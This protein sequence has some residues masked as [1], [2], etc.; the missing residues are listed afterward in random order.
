MS[1][2]YEPDPEVIADLQLR[3]ATERDRSRSRPESYEWSPPK[4]VGKWKCRNPECAGFADV[5]EIAMERFFAFSAQLRSR[6]EGSLDPTKILYCEPCQAAYKA[7]APDRRRA[8]VERMAVEIR[9]L[10]ESGDPTR[11]RDLIAQ[12]EE[13]GHPDVDGLVKAITDRRV[14]DSGRAGKRKPL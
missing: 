9:K 8:Q 11:E 4:I 7:S 5:P 10:K 3:A 2:E 6:G 13:W 14:A 12:L 1:R